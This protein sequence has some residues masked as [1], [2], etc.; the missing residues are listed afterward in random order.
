[1]DQNWSKVLLNL[2]QSLELDRGYEICVMDEAI[3]IVRI[4]KDYIK[5]CLLTL[6]DKYIHLLEFDI[7]G[8]KP[9]E[10]YTKNKRW[11]Y[12]RSGSNKWSAC[13][14]QFHGSYFG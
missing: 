9:D 2:N 8:V 4:G 6:L 1:M 14:G 3:N 12:I 11:R 10:D 5:G 7:M 13:F